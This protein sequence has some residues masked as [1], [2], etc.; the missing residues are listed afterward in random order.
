M[1]IKEVVKRIGYFRY[2][3]NLSARELSLRLDK[4]ESYINK[5]ESNDF[6]L[7]TEMLLK[8]IQSL[9]VSPEEFFSE[10][11]M[12][13]DVDKELYN[14]IQSLSAEKKNHLIEFIKG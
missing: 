6:N 1:E 9:E 2:K 10:N 3:K 7:P 5:L 13:Y 8:I 12:N 11:Y 4:N 14:L